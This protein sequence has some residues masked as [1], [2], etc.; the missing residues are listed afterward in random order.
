VEQEWIEA[1]LQIFNPMKS[2]NLC[3]I[4]QNAWNCDSIT[5]ENKSKG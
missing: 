2:G 3:T 1:Q 5:Y 4:M